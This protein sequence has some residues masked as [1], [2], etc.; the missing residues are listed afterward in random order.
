M[1]YVYLDGP[2]RNLS[3]CFFP[4]LLFYLF[5]LCL[6]SEIINNPFHSSATEPPDLIKKEDSWK[7]YWSHPEEAQTIPLTS[8]CLELNH[9]TSPEAKESG[10]HILACRTLVFS[11]EEGKM[12]FSR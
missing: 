7:V 6:Q 11:M 3:L 10:K 12:D 4:L 1:S 9:M 8:D 5:S 2:F